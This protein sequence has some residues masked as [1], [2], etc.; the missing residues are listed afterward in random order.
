MKDFEHRVPIDPDD[1]GFTGRECPSADCKK[2]F[3]I[4]F[5]TGLKEVSHCFCP[6]C[7][8]KGEQNEFF[9]Q[10]QIDYAVS[11]GINELFKHITPELKKLERKF[12]GGLLSFEMK[13]D[14]S[15]LRQPV[16]H[17]YEK[18][19]ETIVVCEDCTL[20]YTIYGLY[21]FCPDCGH[22]NSKQIFNTNL[23]LIDAYLT[24]ALSAEPV[25]SESLIGDALENL[26]S[27]F[28]AF[29]KATLEVLID[30]LQIQ[31]VADRP[32]FQQIQHARDWLIKNANVD[33]AQDLDSKEWNNVKRCYQKRHAL[34]HKAG[35]IDE[36]YVAKANDSQAV[37]GR[38]ITLTREEVTELRNQL[39]LMAERLWHHAHQ[40]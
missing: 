24:L 7:G 18:E 17:Y 29:G 30:V 3:K 36:L 10:E 1:D 27:Q 16:K 39:S 28:E 38:K 4:E 12:G 13:V 25:V 5:G 8:H 6:Y 31:T 23:Q 37:I 21:G 14:T 19:L 33:I 9:T 11:I 15:K 34:S 32:G 22:H 35:I 26:I 2:Y 20:R 40:K